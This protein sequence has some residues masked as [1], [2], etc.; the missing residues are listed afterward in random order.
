MKKVILSLGKT[1]RTIRFKFGLI[2]LS[3]IVIIWSFFITLGHFNSTDP[4]P[5]LQNIDVE[6]TKQFAAFTVNVET[7]IFI[8][9]FSRFSIIENKFTIDMVVWF[10]FDPTEVTLDTIAKFS[11]E[12]GEIK[13][14]SSPDI[15]IMGDK[16]FVKYDV[17]VDLKSNLR[18]ERF[19]LEDHKLAIILTN[20][21]VTPYEVMFQVLSTDFVVA[22]KIFVANW[23]IQKL[24]TN[25]GIDE[26]ILNQIDKTKKIAYPKAVFTIDLAK[27]G[28]RKIF[29]IFVPIFLVFFFCLFSFFL[30]V[31]NFIGRTTLA[32]SSLSALLGYR[33]VIERLMPKVGYFTTTDSIYIILL[34][35]AFF[36]FIFQV[37]LTRLF[38]IFEKNKQKNKSRFEYLSIAKDLTF[39][40]V[41]V[42]STLLICLNII[43]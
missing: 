33:F 40:V 7:G 16:T 38:N 26:N 4:E 42:L 32:I 13:K 9:N 18:F 15:K 5:H 3:S 43:Q 39:I 17:I 19:P 35:F 8:R 25:F 30:T 11:F 10:L 23:K 1:I 6:L 29:I 20:N 27:D 12:N 31:G 37:V 36:S 24:N 21:F 28:I 2:G 34:A 22:P 14:K 41:T